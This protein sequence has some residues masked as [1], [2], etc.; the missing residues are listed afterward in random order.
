MILASG[1]VLESVAVLVSAVI[2]VSGVFDDPQE[3]VNTQVNK[4]I[5]RLFF[6]NK[7]MVFLIIFF[8]KIYYKSESCCSNNRLGYLTD[9]KSEKY[10]IARKIK[11]KIN[12]CN[13]YEANYT[14]LGRF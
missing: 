5:K 13:F 4:N 14:V 1:V 6:L 11:Q 12:E 3:E 7:A 8:M 10:N 9:I 2:P